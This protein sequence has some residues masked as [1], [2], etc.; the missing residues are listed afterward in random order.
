[1]LLSLAYF[2]IKY[3]GEG[4]VIFIIAS[5]CPIWNMYFAYRFYSKNVHGHLKESLSNLPSFKDIIDF[6]KWQFSFPTDKVDI[7]FKVGKKYKCYKEGSYEILTYWEYDKEGIFTYSSKEFSF[8]D[9]WYRLYQFDK[10]EEI[11]E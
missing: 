8:G 5:L 9:Y 2:M 3:D 10:V 7:T 1:M 6:V 4:R 11:K